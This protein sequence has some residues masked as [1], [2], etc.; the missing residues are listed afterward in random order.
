MVSLKIDRLNRCRHIS[1]ISQAAAQ[2]MVSQ[3]YLMDTGFKAQILHFSIYS[4]RLC[5][6]L[7]NLIT[8]HNINIWPEAFCHTQQS[9][10]THGPV[11]SGNVY[12][13][14][15]NSNQKQGMQKDTR[16]QGW[17]TSAVRATPKNMITKT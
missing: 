9:V 12:S 2:Q 1:V 14:Y 17:R 6:L 8:T 10:T 15:C 13:S 16:A 3:L 5:E 7:R 4:V 11:K